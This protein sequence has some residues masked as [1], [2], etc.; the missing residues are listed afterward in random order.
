[1]KD[2]LLI[3]IDPKPILADYVRKYHIFRFLFEK[4]T[5]PPPKFHAP[6]PEHSITFYIKDAQKFN[7]VN[8]SNVITY[9]HCVI[10]G[11][12]T[13]PIYR[14]GGHDFLAIKVVLQPTALYLLTGLPIK[15]LTNTF[16]NA[17]E[18]WGNEIRMICEQLFN[19]EKLE[20]ILVVIE[21]FLE[22]KFSKLKKTEHPIDKVCQIILLKTENSTIDLLASKSCLSMRQFIRKFEER[23]GVGAKTFSRITQ[24]DRTFRMKNKQPNLN[25]LN[26]AL[27]TGYYDYQHLV[28]DY[29]E[30]TNLTPP[31]FFEKEQKSPE[32]TF[33]LFE[34]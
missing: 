30:F 17:E 19:I 6:R 29:K 33:G 27:S 23:I 31:S 28:K 7:S 22:N 16:I 14:H 15:E 18:L 9:P 26:I 5:I 21:N 10:N 11:I 34:R 12:Y 8:S 3:E 32:R 4:G 1:M 20:T 25:W 2:I 13:T 24:F